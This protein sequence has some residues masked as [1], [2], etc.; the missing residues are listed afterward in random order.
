MKTIH[1]YFHHEYVFQILM[2]LNDT[3]SYIRS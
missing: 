3:F 1:E 2:G